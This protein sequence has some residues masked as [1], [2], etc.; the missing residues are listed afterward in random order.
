MFF[1]KN[2]IIQQIF[3]WVWFCLFN[4]MFVSMQKLLKILFR[5]WNKIQIQTLYLGLWC[6]LK[7]GP[8]YFPASPYTKLVVH[9]ASV[10]PAS[11]LSLRS[12]FLPQGLF[13]CGSLPWMRFPLFFAWLPPSSLSMCIRDAFP[14]HLILLV[15]FRYS[16]SLASVA[17]LH[18]T[19][20]N[21]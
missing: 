18:N 17:S 8:T 4:S 19:Y 3:F 20:Y 15:L 21:L 1:C 16:L 2:E 5:A 13:T 14:P 11:Y 7:L 10:I 12:C 6:L 9:Y